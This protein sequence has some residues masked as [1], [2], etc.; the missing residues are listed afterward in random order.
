[1]LTYWLAGKLPDRG[2][3]FRDEGWGDRN[4]V[5][6]LIRTRVESVDP[7]GKKVILSDGRSIDYDRLLVAAG[8]T[9]IQMALPGID[10]AG[11][12]SLRGPEDAR[13]LMAGCFK[14]LRVIII[15]GGFIGLKLACHLNLRGCQV[16]VLEKMPRLAF[17]AFDDHTSQTVV[18]LLQKRG[19]GVRT[20]VEASEVLSKDN[21]LA[22][23]RLR[24]GEVIEGDRLVQAVGV[25][26]NTSFME[27]LISDAT[28]GLRVDGRMLTAIENI[29]AA[30]DICLTRDAV[31]GE[32]SHNA[33]WPA[34]ARQGSTAGENMAGGDRKYHSSTSSNAMNL[35]GFRIHS[36]GHPYLEGSAGVRTIVRQTDRSHRKLLIQDGRLIGFV[37]AGDVAGSGVLLSLMKRGASLV[38]DDL[39]TGETI[40]AGTK[41]RPPR[42]TPFP[43]E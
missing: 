39:L 21:R 11:V 10:T 23:I 9:P 26:P 28:K 35:F 12:L 27:G 29:Y 34:A 17:R 33:I 25:R 4:E 20:S 18:T 36:A 19:I 42:R 6:I 41:R 5:D 13:R 30:G 14:G 7:A 3:L 24:D 31:T 43:A 8:A 38:E 15:G 40:I 22:G 37:L 32:I 2:L 1:M 16:V